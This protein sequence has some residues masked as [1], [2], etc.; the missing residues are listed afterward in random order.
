V[1]QLAAKEKPDI[2]I[3]LSHLHG[4]NINLPEHAS[5]IDLEIGGGMDV[6]GQPIIVGNTWVINPGKHAECLNQINLNVV[7]GKLVGVVFNQ[8]I[9]NAEMPEN[10]GV[11]SIIDDYVSKMDE[12]L[13]GVAGTTLVD[14]DGERGTV[15]FKESN[16]GNAIADSQIAF[17]SADIALQNGGGIRQSVSAGNI[18]FGDVNGILPFDNKM[19]V[20]EMTGKT[21]WECLDNGVTDY[22]GH[23][24]FLQVGG[25][26]YTADIALPEGKR[27]TKVTLSDGSPLDLTKKYKVVVNDFMAG[28]G[29]GFTMINVLNKNDPNVPLVTDV[30]V[31]VTSDLIQRQIFAD[32][33]SRNPGISPR[34]E[35]RITILNAPRR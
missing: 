16:L 24:H 17:F 14:L 27:V 3:A 30:T 18:T 34:L 10:P 8:I 19:M 32:Y 26:S 5:K 12:K 7:K 25:L 4:K 35:G 2:I 33:L 6:M 1:D 28:G 23:G 11:K 13:Q 15:R 29:D 31:L 20:L 9:L 21:L 22:N